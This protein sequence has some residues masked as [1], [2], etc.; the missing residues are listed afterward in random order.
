MAKA[1][2]ALLHSAPSP[3]SPEPPPFCREL[4]TH[5]C[6]C[7]HRRRAGTRRTA[8]AA[9]WRSWRTGRTQMAPAAPGNT[10]TRCTMWA[11]TSPAGSAPSC[12]RRPCG[13]WRSPGTPTPT[14]EPGEP[15]LGPMSPSQEVTQGH[16]Y[17]RWPP[18]QSQLPGSQ[19]AEP[20][21]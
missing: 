9:A 21:F 2:P 17:W 19:G 12:P 15:A 13:W 20:P 14:L 11:C 7:P 16:R 10:R 6:F 4:Q 5:T 3:G 1:A 8:K 18:R